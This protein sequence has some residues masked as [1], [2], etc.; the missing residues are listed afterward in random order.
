MHR[1]ESVRARELRG[2]AGRARH[3]VSRL[4]GHG[5]GAPADA[6]F[7]RQGESASRCC[8]DGVDIATG[9][10]LDGVM[11]SDVVTQHPDTMRDRRPQDRGVGC[12]FGYCRAVLRD[13][14]SWVTSASIWCSI[15]I[16][17]P[18]VARAQ[19]A[20][21]SRNSNRESSGPVAAFADLRGSRRL[22]G[23]AGGA[24]RVRETRVSPSC[25]RRARPARPRRRSEVSRSH[26]RALAEITRAKQ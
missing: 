4:S 13:H 26:E 23:T 9:V 20:P 7:A 19:C 12:D 5:D 3:R 18:L 10:T 22:Q 16:A 1:L 8:Q 14:R 24:H 25:R 21:R 15:A 6:R 17:R 11:G 2:R